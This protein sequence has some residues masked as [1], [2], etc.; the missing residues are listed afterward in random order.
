MIYLFLDSLERSL[1]LPLFRYITFRSIG[2][3]L[4][5]FFIVFFLA[6]PIIQWLRTKQ[7][8]GQPIR[9][10]GPQGHL[11]S[12]QGIPTM[13]GILLLFGFLGSGLLWADLLNPYILLMLFIT[14]SFAVLGA[15]DD[16]FKLKHHTHH[17][18]T[19]TTKFTVQTALSLIA[20]I[21]VWTLCPVT[22]QGLFHIPLFKHIVFHFGLWM[23]LVSAFVITGAANAVNLT[24]G[25][26]GLAVGP[27]IIA[28]GVFSI[29]VYAAGHAIFSNY[30]QIPHLPGIGEV[31]IL[32]TAFVGACLGFLWYNAPPASIF[33]GDTGSLALGSFLGGLGV[34]S[35]HEI[36]LA[37]VGGVFVMETLSVILQVLYYKRTR[38]RIFLMAPIHHHFEKKGWSE[39]TIVFRFWTIALILGVL[40]LTTLKLR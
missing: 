39:P 11:K 17:G 27:S 34:I 1:G 21:I 2:A 25:L 22:E 37:L 8:K 29:I 10:D 15:V 13:G 40:G 35:K 9:T 14:L 7:K 36:V 24:D 19:A 38:K 6:P 4:T 30:L 3:F 31:T 20:G 23:P 33:M 12:K 18:L 28:I 5:A 32:C 26:D 16:Y